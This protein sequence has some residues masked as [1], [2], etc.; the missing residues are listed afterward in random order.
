MTLNAK[1]LNIKVDDSKR[2]NILSHSEG[3]VTVFVKKL[4][5]DTG[6]ILILEYSNIKN[7]AAYIKHIKKNN[8]HF[9]SY[10]IEGEE[11]TNEGK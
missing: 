6:S 4:N 2:T 10:W 8:P 9:I 3:G 11:P 5:P 1:K 7:V